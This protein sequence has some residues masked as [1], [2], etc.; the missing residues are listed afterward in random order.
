MGKVT[1][2]K[3][4]GALNGFSTVR[5]INVQNGEILASFHRPSGLLLAYSEHQCVMKAVARTAEDMTTA[6]K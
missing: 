6:L 3:T 5:L 2:H 4:G 1:S